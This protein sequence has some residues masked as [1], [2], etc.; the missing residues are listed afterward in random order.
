MF[1]DLRK[2][3]VSYFRFQCSQTWAGPCASPPAGLPG[4]SPQVD[5]PKQ[6]GPG[7]MSTPRARETAGAQDDAAWLPGNSGHHS[8]AAS[9]EGTEASAPPPPAAE[10]RG[11][12]WGAVGWWHRL[13]G[14]RSLH[15]PGAGP[16]D[17][18]LLL[19]PLA[20]AVEPQ[21]P[22]LSNAVVTAAL[23]SP[24]TVSALHLAGHR[25]GHTISDGG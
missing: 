7:H 22:H 25:A 13:G 12:V 19:L 24:L 10:W 17:L 2:T 14:L 11:G 18:T 21:F 9:S 4:S 16:W 6:G 5:F 20:P 8:N 15:G 23:P 3:N 1:S